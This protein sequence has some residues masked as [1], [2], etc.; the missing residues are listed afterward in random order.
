MPTLTVGT[1]LIVRGVSPKH[2]NRFVVGT[3]AEQ[4]TYGDGQ[5]PGLMKVNG[6]AVTYEGMRLGL[7]DEEAVEKSFIAPAFEV[8]TDQAVVTNIQ[9][10][11]APAFKK[12]VTPLDAL[13]GR[14]K[15]IIDDRRETKRTQRESQ[16]KRV[17]LAPATV[18]T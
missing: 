9:T 1:L 11:I 14:L 2:A 17:A 6:K 16:H 10:L 3:L 5:T 7:G 18:G 12:D 8:V 4:V 13:R 15:A